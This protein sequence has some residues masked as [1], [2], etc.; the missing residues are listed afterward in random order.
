[1]VFGISVGAG[2]IIAQ[3]RV[4][5]LI[6]AVMLLIGDCILDGPMLAVGEAQLSIIDVGQGLS[7]LLQTNIT[8]FCMTQGQIPWRVNGLSHLI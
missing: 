8:L 5:T 1:M 4:T 2:V 6:Y 7:V 3:R